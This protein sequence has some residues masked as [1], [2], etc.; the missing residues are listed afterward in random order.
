MT[1]TIVSWLRPCDNAGCCCSVKDRNT[2]TDN[3]GGANG[4][5]CLGLADIE[6][7]LLIESEPPDEWMRRTTGEQREEDPLL[8]FTVD[9]RCTASLHSLSVSVSACLSVCPFTRRQ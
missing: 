8:L 3:P 4:A 9:C 6:L 7:G 2:E 5:K 1:G